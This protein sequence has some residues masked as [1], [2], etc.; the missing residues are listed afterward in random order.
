MAKINAE[1]E[2]QIK[3]MPDQLFDL[4]VRTYG[5]ATPHLTW[6]GE[7]GI[8]IK[9]QFRLSPALAV[10][11]SGAAAVNLLDQAWVKSIELDQ[12]IRTM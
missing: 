7:A 4:I 10:T 12:T 2:Q 1:L 3:S 11:C 8:E 9:Q 5:D 6:C